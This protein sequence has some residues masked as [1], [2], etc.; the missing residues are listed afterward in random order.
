MPPKATVTTVWSTT[1]AR[2]SVRLLPLIVALLNV[3][4]AM[5]NLLA[6]SRPSPATMFLLKVNTIFVGPSLRGS[7]VTVVPN[8]NA[9]SNVPALP[10]TLRD[11]A[12]VIV[13][14]V[15]SI[16]TATADDAADCAMPDCVCLA[17]ML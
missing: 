4:L 9:M 5:V 11:T 1:A 6:L 10:C 15:V 13:G 14:L 12:A 8:A 17:T 3:A 2:F 16:V 7:T